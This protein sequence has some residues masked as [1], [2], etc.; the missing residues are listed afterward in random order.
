MLYGAGLRL[1]EL[2]KVRLT[3]INSENMLICVRKA[4]GNKD[5]VVMLSPGLLKD[6][7]KV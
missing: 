3:D 6:L 2:L 5:R 1:G 7:C 4:K